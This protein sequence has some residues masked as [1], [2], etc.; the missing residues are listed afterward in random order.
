[1]KNQTIKPGD[2][3]ECKHDESWQRKHVASDVAKAQKRGVGF[4]LGNGAAYMRLDE[5][6]MVLSVTPSGGL[7]LRGFAPTV[8]AND[9]QLSTQPVYR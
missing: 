9:V 8:S 5:G 6:Y 1:M 3:V 4:H 2:I 7:K